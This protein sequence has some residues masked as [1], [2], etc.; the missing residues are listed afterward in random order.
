MSQFLIYGLRD[1]RTDEYRYIGKSS[2]GLIRAQSHLTYSHNEGVNLWVHELRGENLLPFVD[3]FEE[4]DEDT[5]MDKEK[6][7]I[8]HYEKVGCRLFNSIRYRG[9]GIEKLLE[10]IRR[11][12]KELEDTLNRL[13]TEHADVK[14]LGG[15]IKTRRKTL[16]LRQ[17]DLAEM[18]GVNA[19]TIS[20]LENNDA[21]V[22]LQTAF[23][24][25]DIL[26]C[27]LQPVIKKLM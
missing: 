13:A 25:L 4:C 20:M 9:H 7:W 24:I 10:S 5:L 3:V 18:S 19:R 27:T 23:K 26:G 11:E 15:Y 14:T 2:S 22:T 1:P 6:F 21:N 12:E 8:Q 17:E 16:K